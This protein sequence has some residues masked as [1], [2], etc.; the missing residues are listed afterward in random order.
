MSLLSGGGALF[1]SIADAEAETFER[2]KIRQIVETS[3]QYNSLAL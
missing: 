2:A 3:E 1:P